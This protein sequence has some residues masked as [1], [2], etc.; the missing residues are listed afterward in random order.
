MQVRLGVIRDRVI[1]Q[2]GQNT[3]RA[4]FGRAVAAGVC[5]LGLGLLIL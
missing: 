1:E 3:A 5:G 2:R 4:E